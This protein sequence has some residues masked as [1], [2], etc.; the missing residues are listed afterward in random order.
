MKA[1]FLAVDEVKRK[2][3]DKEIKQQTN[4]QQKKEKEA[5]LTII[6]KTEL[7]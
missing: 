4:K 3:V 5:N 1:I 7:P 6:A 2:K